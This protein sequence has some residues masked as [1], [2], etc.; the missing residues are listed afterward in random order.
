MSDRSLLEIAGLKVAFRAGAD[1][2]EVVH[3]IDLTV[4][5]GEAVGL[6]GES[7]SGKSVAALSTLR[8]LGRHGVVTGG[9][10][11]FDGTDLLSLD[12][13]QMRKVRGKDI[14]MI[15]QDPTMALNPAF[16]IGAQILDVI[17]AHQAPSRTRARKE[18]LEALDR[19]G[20]R[21]PTTVMRSYPHE[22][23]GGMRQRAMI[24]MAI[25]C[26]PKLVLADEPTTA[27][28]V[29]VQAQIVELLR[30]LVRELDLSLLFITHNLDLMSD[31][32]SR[33]VVL[34]QGSVMESGPTDK[35]F[36]RPAHPYTKMLFD[37]IARI[38][39][40]P[41]QRR[42]ARGWQDIKSA[43]A[44]CAFAPRCPLALPHCSAERPALQ[45]EGAGN[46]ACWRA[47]EVTR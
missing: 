13:A 19:V 45:P 36:D 12:E 40:R 34:Y 35:L 38:E 41:A 28:D 43:P 29:T 18:A 30:R 26:K 42:P 20:F 14:S 15:F 25:A 37:S 16:T 46:V 2:R 32:C 22:L 21:E 7:G 31:L 27:L 47:G 5:R 4:G 17:H 9:R 23:S 8:L 6:V 33:A 1:L 10:I 11:T 24:A 39:R 3:G 44:G